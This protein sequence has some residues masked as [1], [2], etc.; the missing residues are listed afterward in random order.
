MLFYV[1][2]SAPAGVNVLYEH[3][4]NGVRGAGGNVTPISL[5]S[6]PTLP[7]RGFVGI[8]PQ[9]DFYSINVALRGSGRVSCEVRIGSAIAKGRTQV[10]SGQCAATLAW[11]GAGWSSVPG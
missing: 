9:D 5:A 7:Y 3:G 10:R 6:N 1:S 2:G 11:N 8:R 4:E